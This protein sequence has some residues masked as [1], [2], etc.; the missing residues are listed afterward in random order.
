MDKFEELD[1]LMELQNVEIGLI[2]LARLKFRVWEAL[3]RCEKS[4]NQ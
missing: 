1:Q 2:E 4:A 3:R